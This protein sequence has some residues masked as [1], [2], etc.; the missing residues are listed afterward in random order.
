MKMLLLNILLAILWMAMWDAFDLWTLGSGLVL[1][2]LVLGLFS[3]TIKGRGYGSKL[4]ALISFVAYF[5]RI[6]IKANLQVAWEITTPGF[7]MQPRIVRYKV[8][9]LTDV[10]LTTLASAIS[11]TPGTLSVDVSDDQQYLYVHAMYAR[12]RQDA[13]RDLDE[14][15]KRLMKEVFG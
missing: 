10:Q 12:S 7:T 13:I 9:H 6:L 4:W 1:G 8:D 15:Q 5:L 3:R 11:L 2:Y 14:L